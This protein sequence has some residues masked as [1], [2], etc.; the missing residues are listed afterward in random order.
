MNWSVKKKNESADQIGDHFLQAKAYAD[1]YG[2]AQEGKGW[3]VQPNRIQGHEDRE[4]DESDP[5]ELGQQ[6]LE[7]RWYV[8]KSLDA[9]L[10]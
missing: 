6:D 1:T 3:K 8:G 2:A 5:G 7:G 10:D 9:F 4:E